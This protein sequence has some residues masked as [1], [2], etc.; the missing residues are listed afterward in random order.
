MNAI[1]FIK[2]HGVEKARKVIEGAPDLAKYYSTIDGEYYRIELHAVNLRHLKRL[3][4]SVDL[5]NANGGM[6]NTSIKELLGVSTCTKSH[7]VFPVTRDLNQVETDI[8]LNTIEE[9]AEQV[10]ILNLEK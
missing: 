8:E 7:T 6:G 5:I 10:F 4:E 2:E 1:Q 9:F 3:V